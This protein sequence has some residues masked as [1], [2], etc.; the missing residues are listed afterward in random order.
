MLRA[1]DAKLDLALPVGRHPDVLHPRTENGGVHVLDP[2]APSV[3]VEVDVVSLVAGLMA[4]GEEI[5]ELE[6]GVDVDGCVFLENEV[7]D[8]RA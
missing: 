6:V 7:P 1:S 5:R 8:Q 2:M 4:C 3:G